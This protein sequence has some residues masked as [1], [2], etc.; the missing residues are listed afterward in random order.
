MINRQKTGLKELEFLRKLNDADPDDKFHC[1]RLFRHFYH[2]QHLCL[3]F[4]PLR[5]WKGESLLYHPL[6]YHPLCDPACSSLICSMN[7]REVLKKY[8]KDVGLH[9]KAVRSYSQQ[10]FLALKLLK[11]CN[12]LHADIKPD[13]I[14]VLSN[15]N[16]W[17]NQNGS[18]ACNILM[19]LCFFK[20]Q[21]V[22]NHFEALR[23]RFCVTCCRQWHHTV[24]RQQILQSSWN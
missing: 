23:L 11:R 24:S 14:L 19:H 8:G 21:R 3:V 17:T 9:I 15:F 22:K 5:Y 10:L 7:L 2:K 13:N 12:I 6:L 16:S 20:G 1:L 4:E 18:L